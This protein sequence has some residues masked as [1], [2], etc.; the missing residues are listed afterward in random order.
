MESA[1]KATI[2][3]FLT[4]RETAATGILPEN[5]IRRL[6]KDGSIPVLRVGV[7]QLINFDRLLEQLDAV[8]QADSEAAGER[9]W[10]SIPPFIKCVERMQ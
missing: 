3:R 5:A 6:V 1:Q 7:K 10:R 9:I 4:I 2:P 8:S